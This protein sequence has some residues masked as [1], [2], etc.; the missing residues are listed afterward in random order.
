MKQIPLVVPRRETVQIFE[1]EKFQIVD[2]SLN[3][4][5]KITAGGLPY[6]PT[7]VGRRKNAFPNRSIGA[8]EKILT[9]GLKRTGRGMPTSRPFRWLQGYYEER[10]RGGI[11][12]SAIKSSGKL[13]Q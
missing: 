4:V 8:A 3:L 6:A 9:P 7:H 10:L 5:S 13:R 11:F 12:S 2:A 1:T